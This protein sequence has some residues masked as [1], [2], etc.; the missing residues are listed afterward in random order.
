LELISSASG[1]WLLLPPHRTP[2][3]SHVPIR[4][5]QDR[6]KECFHWIGKGNDFR[7]RFE[8]EILE[9]PVGRSSKLLGEKRLQRLS[10]WCGLKGES[11]SERTPHNIVIVYRRTLNFFCINRHLYRSC[12]SR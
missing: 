1:S 6:S 11:R 10:H 5:I 9:W 4:Y 7:C 12:H 8:K 3:C 2:L